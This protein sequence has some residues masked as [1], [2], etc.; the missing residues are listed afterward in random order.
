MTLHEWW[1]TDTGERYWVEITDRSS[2]GEDLIAPKLTGSGST[3]SGYELLRAVE[4]GDIVFHWWKQGS[5]APAFVGFSQAVSPA[6]SSSLVWQAKGTSGRKQAGAT[7]RPAWRVR[8]TGYEELETHVDLD[9][10]RR[11]ERR[12]HALADRLEQK[13]GRPL[14]FPFALSAKRP[15]RTAQAYF[16]KVPAELVDLLPELRTAKS[17]PTFRSVRS[18]SLRPSGPRPRKPDAAANREVEVYAMT[19]AAEYLDAKGFLFEDVSASNPYD[20]LALDAEANEVHVEVKGR[21]GSAT[22]VDLTSGEVQDANSRGTL[23]ILIVID[24]IKLTR[25]GRGFHCSGGRLRSWADWQPE[26]QRLVATA[27]RY[28]LPEDE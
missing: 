27:Y 22:T 23:S 25:S 7:S 2:L 12:I 17:R 6:E 14:Y 5:S 18:G 19:K 3:T 13:Y 11:R 20:Y 24:Q 28:T 8:L 15:I 4:P 26:R 21:T 1:L 10:I 9:V 16:A